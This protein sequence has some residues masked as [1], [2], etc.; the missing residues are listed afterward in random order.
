LLTRSEPEERACK[1]TVDGFSA[2]KRGAGEG[3]ENALPEGGPTGDPAM[4]ESAPEMT[5]SESEE[6][7]QLPLSRTDIE[8]IHALRERASRSKASGLTQEGG[9]VHAEAVAPPDPGSETCGE[10]VGGEAVQAAVQ[11][12]KRFYKSLSCNC[13]TTEDGE[14]DSMLRGGE[15][16]ITTPWHCEICNI[17]FTSSQALGGHRM[18]SNDH[19]V[20]AEKLKGS[21]GASALASQVVPS[22]PRLSLHVY[23]NDES[24][25]KAKR[26]RMP[27]M[28]QMA[29]FDRVVIN[30][31]D[32]VR[33]ALERIPSP[34]AFF[35]SCNLD[36][37][38][39]HAKFGTLGGSRHRCRL[40]L[41]AL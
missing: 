23:S 32:D 25:G 16:D 35:S 3:S 33:A 20:R 19:K 18:N 26:T 8:T 34:A 31:P 2:T 14:E 29:G 10:R 41:V 7:S 30:Y 39:R 37:F 28:A 11:S 38:K 27:P 15:A 21:E 24:V 1:R 9:L 22:T 40:H 17:Y 4:G 12:R 5:E 13:W 6:P 36:V